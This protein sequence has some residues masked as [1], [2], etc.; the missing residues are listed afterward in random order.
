MSFL[1]KNFVWILLAIAL[2]GEGVFGYMLLGKQAEAKKA[3]NDLETKKSLLADLRRKTVDKDKRLDAYKARR[4]A[5]EDERGDCLLFLWARTQRI[6]GLFP[7]PALA[8]FNP[9]PWRKYSDADLGL[10]RLDYQKAYDA[11]VGAMEG[12][13]A[14]VRTSREAVGFPGPN[15]FTN[16]QVTLG[17]IYQEQKDFWVRKEIVEAAAKAGVTRVD[18][19]RISLPVRERP[20]AGHA[21]PPSTLKDDAEILVRLQCT[22]KAWTDFLYNMGQSPLGFRVT[23]ISD[24]IRQRFSTASGSKAKTVR[25]T[26]TVTETDSDALQGVEG[27]V[28]FALPLSNIAIDTVTFPAKTF[29]GGTKDVEKYVKD[30]IRDL[31]KDLEDVSGKVSGS[32][33]SEQ[34]AK[35]PEAPAGSDA[36]K[37]KKT[38]PKPIIIRDELMGGGRDYKF[39]RAEDATR[40]IE[41]RPDFEARRIEARLALWRRVEAILGDPKRVKTQAGVVVDV[42]PKEHLDKKADKKYAFV[43]DRKAGVQVDFGLLTFVPEISGAVERRSKS[44]N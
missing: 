7:T 27:T 1:R 39:E 35:I 43:I 6:A 9:T 14:K 29:R 23:K 34:L 21:A 22:Y 44:D 38:E 17:D 13:L 31:E 3:A 19:L 12:T 40:W 4:Q 32:W 36:E 42:R 2:I 20:S 11:A 5:V 8:K 33:R 30:Q 37:T 28:I 24:L 16:A 18:Q 15:A 25:S 41:K 10:F 26:P